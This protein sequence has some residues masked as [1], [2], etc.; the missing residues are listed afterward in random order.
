MSPR[1]LR[2]LTAGAAAV[3]AAWLLLGTAAPA[4]AATQTVVAGVSAPTP[5]VDSPIQGVTNPDGTITVIIDGGNFGGPGEWTITG[6]TVNGLAPTSLNIA[7]GTQ[8]VA[9]WP[10][11]FTSGSVTVIIKESTGQIF[12]I[13]VNLIVAPPIDVISSTPTSPTAAPTP[14]PAPT[15]A[16]GPDGGVFGLPAPADEPQTYTPLVQ[17]AGG[18]SGGGVISA[19]LNDPLGLIPGL[20]FSRHP[21]AF[22]ATIILL[23]GGVILLLAPRRRLRRTTSAAEHVA[24]MIDEYASA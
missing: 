18:G 10:P 3:A 2:A 8:I 14:A 5:V 1:K 9:T 15:A 23:G 7:S 24:A 16:G 6:L 21:V 13:P 12:S 22:T 11:D 19:I 4:Q 20:A 17:A